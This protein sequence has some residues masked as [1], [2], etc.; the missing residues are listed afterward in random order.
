MKKELLLSPGL[1]ASP[2]QVYYTPPLD[3][4]LDHHKCTVLSPGWE[5]R[6]SLLHYTPP[7][8]R[9]DHHKYTV[10]SPG[11]EASPSQVHCTPPWMGD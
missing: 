4:R 9:L 10:L 11:W 7:D 1:G 5:A 3:G 2:S 6:V 8:G